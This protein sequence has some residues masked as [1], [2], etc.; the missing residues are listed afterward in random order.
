RV[1]LG[2]SQPQL[3]LPPGI[4]R[5]PGQART[6]SRSA[7]RASAS[8]STARSREVLVIRR[9]G[10]TPSPL[11]ADGCEGTHEQPA[12]DRH[13]RPD[14]AAVEVGSPGARVDAAAFEVGILDRVDIDRGAVG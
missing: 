5:A 1:N 6:P 12:A 2:R 7:S 11:P 8:E 13:P 14:P 3:L 4:R 9:A 10:P